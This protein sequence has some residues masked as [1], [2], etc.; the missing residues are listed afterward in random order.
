VNTWRINSRLGFPLKTMI[1]FFMLMSMSF[2]NCTGGFDAKEN[3]SSLVTESSNSEASLNA[4]SQTLHPL[5]KINCGSCHGISQAPQFAVLD[6]RQAHATILER[7]LVNLSNPASSKIV[8][9]IAG[10]HSGLPA[11]LS[12]QLAAQI[13]AWSAGMDGL[14]SEPIDPPPPGPQPPIL[15]SISPNPAPANT[16]FVIVARG[17]NFAASSI[18]VILDANNNPLTE[19]A[20]NFISAQEVHVPSAP[21]GAPAG[22]Y[23]IRIRNADGRLSATLPITL[24]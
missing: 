24:Q 16:A 14:P 5:I 22:R 12:N 2:Q 4:F 23:R 19:V 9:K 6:A 1:L 13:Q 8:L 17:A 20:V 18:M 3:Y 7:T 10:G 21:G 11:N 15:N